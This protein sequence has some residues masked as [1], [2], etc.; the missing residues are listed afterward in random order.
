[1]DPLPVAT[2]EPSTDDRVDWRPVVWLL[3]ANLLSMLL[4]FLGSSE[5][6]SNWEELHTPSA[7]LMILQGYFGDLLGMQYMPF[8]GGCSVDALLDI[9]LTAIAGP[10]LLLWKLVPWAF[11]M[12]AIAAGYWVVHRQTGRQAAILYGLMLVL[13]P[14]AYHHLVMMGFSNHVQVM[15]LVWLALVAWTRALETQGWRW[16]FLLGLLLGTSFYYCYTAAFAPPVLLLLYLAWRPRDLR[17][18][19]GLALLGGLA[20]PL[21]WWAWAQAHMPSRAGTDVPFFAVYK[22]GAASLFAFSHVLQRLP[23]LG[24]T[25]WRSLFAPSLGEETVLVGAGVAAVLALGVVAVTWRALRG[26]VRR[27]P[28][29][30]DVALPAL[31]LAFLAMYLLVDS[32]ASAP[33]ARSWHPEI[34]RYQAP[35]LSLAAACAAGTIARLWRG[36]ARGLAP[37]LALL[38][39]GPGLTGRLV[40]IEPDRLTLRPLFLHGTDWGTISNRINVPEVESVDD[41][42]AFVAGRDRIAR[43]VLLGNLAV[44][45]GDRMAP[46]HLDA[47]IRRLGV[48]MGQLEE[49]DRINLLRGL[50][51]RVEELARRAGPGATPL[52][53][54]FAVLDSPSAC[55]LQ[56]ERYRYD[57]DLQGAFYQAL[58]GLEPLAGP[59][60]E[61]PCGAEAADWFL[62]YLAMSSAFIANERDQHASLEALTRVQANLVRLQPEQ[63]AVF[64]EGA[65]ERAGEL[66]GYDPWARRRLLDTIPAYAEPSFEAGFTRGARWSF[67]WPLG[68]WQAI[69]RRCPRAGPPSPRSPAP[70]DR[71]GRWRGCCRRPRP[72][73]S[74]RRGRPP[75]R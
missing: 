26:L 67:V 38:V 28:R 11:S 47:S 30:L 29:P 15:G 32:G 44:K 7:A 31:T 35:L 56:R 10:S 2:A 16:P 54:V 41:V 25:C 21:G 27:D 59:A 74:G 75:R 46:E 18:L 39:L 19:R 69:S 51:P 34:L 71:A 73:G 20:L 50:T 60:L 55:L 48:W 36:R 5:G 72:T 9:P 17:R 43:R 3:G 13:A 57:A 58:D 40:A 68:S 33:L 37:V 63:R 61:G 23:R 14:T 65:A 64:I 49:E 8:C 70:G 62:G 66:W 24:P 45:L 22:S 6:F 12:L 42:G 52:Q 1:M 4:Y 53:A